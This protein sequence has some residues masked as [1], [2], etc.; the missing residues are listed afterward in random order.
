MPELSIEGQIGASQINKGERHS[1]QREQQLLV[2]EDQAEVAG[3]VHEKESELLPMSSR[4]EGNDGQ[5]LDKGGPRDPQPWARSSVRGRRLMLWA[6][7]PALP[8][9]DDRGVVYSTPPSV[10]LPLSSFLPL[11]PTHLASAT[12]PPRIP[13]VQPA[14]RSALREPQTVL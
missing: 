2:T 14:Q 7:G 9:D 10:S 4:T 1:S 11:P 3:S 12:P 13:E 5:F 6:R 8:S